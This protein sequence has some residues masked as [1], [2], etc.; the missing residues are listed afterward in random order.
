MVQKQQGLFL[1][2]HTIQFSQINSVTSHFIE[3]ILPFT[4]KTKYISFVIRKTKESLEKLMLVM[5][6]FLFKG[7]YKKD[8]K[9]QI[10][11]T[12]VSVIANHFPFVLYKK[13]ESLGVI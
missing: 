4:K 11:L 12:Q 7:K 9:K 6:F 1:R 2:P 8:V 3:K 5:I 10:Q 13:D